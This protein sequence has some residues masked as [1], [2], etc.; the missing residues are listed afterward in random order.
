MVSFT[1]HPF[2]KEEPS[3]YYNFKP[4]ALKMFERRWYLIGRDRDS[5]PHHSYAL[6]RITDCELQEDTYTR[7]PEFSLE[8]MFDGYYGIIRG[9]SDRESSPVESIWLKVEADQANYLRSLPLHSSQLELRRN[10]EYSL[11]SVRVRPTFDFKQK[12]LSMGSS[13]EVVKP[14]SFRAEVREEIAA[15]LGNYREEE[16]E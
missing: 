6:D 12:I 10:D 9:D 16:D 8:E 15:M 5:K 1:H 13:V 14:E 7:D 2:G 11:F 3:L 4:H